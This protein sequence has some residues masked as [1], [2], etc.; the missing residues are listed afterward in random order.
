MN[1]NNNFDSLNIDDNTKNKIFVTIEGEEFQKDYRELG[2]DFNSS[3]SEIMNKI[4]PIINEL[5][6][7]DI[8]GLYKVRKTTT[9]EN[10]FIIPN[11]TAG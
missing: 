2:I 9:N 5:Y 1:E 11:S 6:N 7:V 10:I 4:I 8:T 3:E